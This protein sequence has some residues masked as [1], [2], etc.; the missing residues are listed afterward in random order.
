[1]IHLEIHRAG[2]L[3]F[4]DSTPLSRMKRSLTELAEY[5]YRGCDYRTGCYLMTGTCLVPPNDFTLNAN[6]EVTIRIDGIGTLKNTVA[7]R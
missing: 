3:M 1:M 2:K 6:D 4:E 7:I 5:L